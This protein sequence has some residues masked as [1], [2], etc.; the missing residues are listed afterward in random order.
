MLLLLRMGQGDLEGILTRGLPDNKI[1]RACGRQP[2]RQGGLYRVSSSKIQMAK[3]LPVL[4]IYASIS[5]LGIEPR[6]QHLSSPNFPVAA[7]A[8]YITLSRI[9]SIVAPNPVV[10]PLAIHALV[11]PISL[12]GT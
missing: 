5:R 9:L 11:I 8:I 4:F 6:A 2:S 12:H 7:I 3:Y 10:S 1:Q